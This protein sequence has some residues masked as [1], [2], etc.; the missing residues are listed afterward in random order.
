[1]SRLEKTGAEMIL[2]EPDPD[3]AG[4]GMRKEYCP[5]SL[6]ILLTIKTKK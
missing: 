2:K 6:V 4:V 1:V 3:H 5:T